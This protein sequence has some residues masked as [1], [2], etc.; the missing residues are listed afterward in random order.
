ML[1]G[2]W[3]VALFPCWIVERALYVNHEQGRKAH[4]SQDTHHVT[5]AFFVSALSGAAAER[6]VSARMVRDECG[7]S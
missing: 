6:I 3:I 7:H 1:L 5:T 2:I 4:P